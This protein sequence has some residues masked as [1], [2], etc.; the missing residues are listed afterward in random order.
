MLFNNAV[1]TV[2]SNVKEP[3]AVIEHVRTIYLK[4][5]PDETEENE[6]IC[7]SVYPHDL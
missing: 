5:F 1:S 3:I 2:T 6:Y 7:Q 4:D